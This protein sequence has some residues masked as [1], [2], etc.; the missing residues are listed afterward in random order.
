MEAKL[1]ESQPPADAAAEKAPEA[2]APKTAQQEPPAPKKEEKG[3]KIRGRMDLRTGR[4]ITEE[5]MKL[6]KELDEAQKKTKEA[7]KELESESQTQK[8]KKK[9]KKKIRE[10]APE[11]VTTPPET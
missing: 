8:K 6:R 2:E 10:T 1:P 5:E 4:L 3:L 9:K 11:G 7:E